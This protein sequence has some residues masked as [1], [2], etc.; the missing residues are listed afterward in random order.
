MP[1]TVQQIAI[2][3][4]VVDELKE[5]IKWKQGVSYDFQGVKNKVPV[6]NGTRAEYWADW[7][8]N[9]PNYISSGAL[10][11]ADGT[12]STEPEPF[13]GIPDADGNIKSI[14]WDWWKFEMEYDV[15]YEQDVNGDW[16]TYISNKQSELATEEAT[17]A[18]M[19]ADPA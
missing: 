17:L 13:T 10:Y 9:H 7:R 5:D 19:Q 1:Y 15:G 11:N 14:M 18:T 3:Q 6:W 16:A 8:T 4:I 12:F 2:Q